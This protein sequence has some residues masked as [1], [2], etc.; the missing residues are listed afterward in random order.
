MNKNTSKSWTEGLHIPLVTKEKRFLV[1]LA[2][3]CEEYDATFYYTTDDDGI[4]IDLDDEEIFHDFMVFDLPAILK[5]AAWLL[6]NP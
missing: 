2:D 6:P 1:A 3:I 4:H 5:T